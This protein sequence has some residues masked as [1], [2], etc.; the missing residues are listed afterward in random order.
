MREPKL[1]CGLCKQPIEARQ[2]VVFRPDGSL[3]HERC[4][5]LRKPLDLKSEQPDPICP[6]CSEPISGTDGVV[7]HRQFLGAC[8]ATRARSRVI[9]AEAQRLATEVGLALAR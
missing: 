1:T 3:D 5:T 9:A 6:A 2:E 4:R 8:A 7:K